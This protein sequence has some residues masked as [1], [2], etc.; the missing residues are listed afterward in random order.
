MSSMSYCI[1]ENITNDLYQVIEKL[2]ELKGLTLKEIEESMSEYEFKAF[3][4]FKKQL[5]TIQEII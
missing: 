3:L 1:F 5:Q 2:E 4:K